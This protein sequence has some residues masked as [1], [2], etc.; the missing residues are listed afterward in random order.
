MGLGQTMGLQL[1]HMCAP[2]D[3]A[4]HQ[5]CCL[6]RFD[7]LRG[8]REGHAERARKLANT[9]LCKRQ[10]MQHRPPGRIGESVEYGVQ[11]FGLMFNHK[12]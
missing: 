11:P 6:Q 1:A 5:S 3:S 9:A 12:V 10:A 4:S 8:R 7:V 2:L